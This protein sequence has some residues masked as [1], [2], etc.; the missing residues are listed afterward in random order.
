MKKKLKQCLFNNQ[1][2]HQ[3]YFS[4]CNAKNVT[5]K[6]SNFTQYYIF[7]INYTYNFFLSKF[8]GILGKISHFTQ[9]SFKLWFKK[10]IF[11]FYNNN[12]TTNN[13]ILIIHI[14]INTLNYGKYNK[15]TAKVHP[16]VIENCIKYIIEYNL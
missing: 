13:K 9:Y 7:Y 3:I 5:F 1:L 4:I 8:E 11:W 16:I 12:N 10:I 14:F 2:I 15:K 6:W